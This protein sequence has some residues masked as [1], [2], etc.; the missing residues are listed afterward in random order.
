MKKVVF[1][2]S[3]TSMAFIANAQ[4][5]NFRWAKQMGGTGSSGGG[6]SITT[7]VV[8]NVY[9]TGFFTGT[10]DFDPGPGIFN[11][12]GGGMF[13]SKLD[14]NGNFVWAKQVAGL[15]SLSGPL[16]SAI[17]LDASGNIYTTETLFGT[18]DFDPGTGT[19]NLSS[20][21][22]CDIFVHKMSKCTNSTSSVLTVTD[23]KNYTLNG[24]TYTVSG[25]YTQ[26]I[27]NTAGCDST[28]T[29]NLT[30]NRINTTINE[31]S[32]TTYTWNGNTYNSSGVYVDTLITAN[33][34][35]SIVT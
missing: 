21:G 16:A 18:V 27:L 6:E 12:T 32:C 34:C 1:I 11:L 15:G 17:T 35:D 9:T 20:A 4:I 3:L 8:G 29:L 2:F 22:I 30:I 31:S 7:D 33:G 5:V 10:V 14:S 28:I 23:C 13:V 25:V 24:H 19:Y 26:N